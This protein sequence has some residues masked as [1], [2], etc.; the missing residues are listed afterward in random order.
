MTLRGRIASPLIASADEYQRLKAKTEL[1]RL[2]GRTAADGLAIFRGSVFVDCNPALEDMF[3]RSRDE[4]LGRTP[5]Q[6]GTPDEAAAEEAR[7]VG[8]EYLERAYAGEPVRFQWE[9]VMRD[10]ELR[11]HDVAMT[12]FDLDD[13]P[14]LFCWVRD[15]TEA[16][17]SQRELHR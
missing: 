14:R 17:Q 9:H 16:V 6:I 4:I 8:E 12:R 5:W 10:H 1:F 7:V 2:I 11:I 13:G 3:N 15:V